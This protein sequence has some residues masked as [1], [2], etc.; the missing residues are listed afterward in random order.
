M[1]GIGAQIAVGALLRGLLRLLLLKVRLQLK[2]AAVVDADL[3]AQ[4]VHALPA[5]GDVLVDLLLVIAAQNRGKHVISHLDVLF[6]EQ[7]PLPGT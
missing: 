3:L 5:A 2:N 4:P 6:L 7:R 1:L